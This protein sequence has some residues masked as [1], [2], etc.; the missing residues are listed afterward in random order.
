MKLMESRTGISLEE[1]PYDSTAQATTEALG[2][3]V[4]L[5]IPSLAGGMPLVSC[6]RSS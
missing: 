2:G 5:H 3:H 1:I 6:G 4:E